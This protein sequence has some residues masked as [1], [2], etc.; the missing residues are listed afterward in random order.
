MG[1]GRPNV[2]MPIESIGKTIMTSIEKIKGY[3]IR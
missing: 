1:R 2:T 3:E